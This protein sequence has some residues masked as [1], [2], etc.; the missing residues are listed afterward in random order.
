M[1]VAEIF[2]NNFILTI[3]SICCAIVIIAHQLKGVSITTISKEL[4]SLPYKLFFSFLLLQFI[5]LIVLWR[6]DTVFEFV[7]SAISIVCFV[8]IVY[9]SRKKGASSLTKFLFPIGL[10]TVAGF[11]AG[12]IFIWTL[13]LFWILTGKTNNGAWGDAIALG[14]LVVCV[15][16]T[17][18]GLLF[19][20]IEAVVRSK[21]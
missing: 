13:L 1:A 12:W 2:Q 20:T 9:F 6:G 14:A 5:C 7:T 4:S 18:V 16:S 3:L 8:V 15:I 19:G 11:F 10:F 17:A 21:V